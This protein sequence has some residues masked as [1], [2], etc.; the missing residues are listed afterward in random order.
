MLRGCLGD[1]VDVVVA[2]G[3]GEFLR[4]VVGDLGEDQGG[5]GGGLGGGRGGAL[6]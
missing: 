2:V 6:G 3:V 4:C 5:K 1:V